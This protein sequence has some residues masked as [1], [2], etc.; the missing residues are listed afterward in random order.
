MNR[1]ND[2]TDYAPL[3][4]EALEELKRLGA[5]L[6]REQA[7]RTEPIAVVGLGC[8]FP[9][10]SDPDAYWELLRSGRDAITS[11]PADRWDA[12]ALLDPD[13]DAPG[14]IVTREGGFCDAVDQF[15]ARFFNISDRE[16]RE[17]DPQQRLLMEVSWEALENAGYAADRLY[18]S[19]AGVFVGIA[20]SDYAHLR[21]S[22]GGIRMI[23]AYSGTGNAHSVAAG[24]I[25]YSLGLKGP[26]LAVDTACSSSLV[27]VHLAVQSLRNNECD[28][29]LAGGV[30]LILAPGMSV[31]FSRVR[32]LSPNGRCRTFDAA[33]DG[34]V[35]GEGCGMIVLRRLSDA[36]ADGDRVLAVLRGSAV[37]HDGRSAGLTAPN[38]PSQEAVLNAAL[39]ESGLRPEE[40]DYI[41]AHGTGTPLGD[42][43]ELQAVARTYCPPDRARPLL[44]GSAKT[45]FGHL[46]AAAGIAGL[47]KLV[48]AIRHRQIPPNL[49]FREWNPHIA[50]DRKAVSV[51][52]RLQPWPEGKPSAVGA[53][54]SF[55]FSGT[56]AHIIVESAQVVSPPATG[57]K[58]LVLP[59]SAKSRSAL[60][61]LA[62]RYTA[63][64]R[65]AA[66]DEWPS[67]CHT[68]ALGRSHFQHRLAMVASSPAEAALL[69][70]AFV[71][72][73]A[74]AGVFTEASSS[75]AAASSSVEE[76]TAADYAAGRDVDWQ[77]LFGETRPL[78]AELPTYPFERE[79]Y[80]HDSAESDGEAPSV[81]PVAAS[82]TAQSGARSVAST[83]N[84][85]ARLG[86]R[87]SG[88]TPI[89]ESRPADGP[90]SFVAD[91]GVAGTPVV[92]GAAWLDLG[93]AA[94]AAIDPAGRYELANITFERLLPQAA[95]VGRTLEL[96]VL[97]GIDGSEFQI[98]SYHA[99]SPAGTLHARGRLRAAAEAEV[100]LRSGG[101]GERPESIAA[102]LG[103]SLDAAALYDRLE[104]LGLHYGP[105][106]RA[107]VGQVRHA[108]GEAL[109]E[110]CVGPTSAA[111][112]LPPWVIDACLQV[113]AAAV[114]NPAGSAAKA[115]SGL[116][117]NNGPLV[118]VGV[119]RAMI[120]APAGEKVFSHVRFR[121][122]AADAAPAAP[123]VDVRV[124]DA[125]GRVIA[126]FTGLRFAAASAARTA[127]RPKS[128]L[129]RL[130]KKA[131]PKAPG[132]TAVPA[133]G[134]G[135]HPVFAVEPDPAGEATLN[136]AALLAVPASQ[137]AARLSDYLHDRLLHALGRRQGTLDRNES[138]VNLGLDSL[139]V[140]KLNT[141]L[142]RALS[143]ELPMHLLLTGPSITQITELLLQ[144]LKEE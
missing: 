140:I 122:P 82:S 2:P 83:T 64:L 71:A 42:P 98:L 28:L 134:G 36:L 85:Q 16:A 92:P 39:A 10:A 87:L 107:V 37:N 118:P 135:L 29:A 78:R 65:G 119:D 38:G 101:D 12:D 73:G 126:E 47:I 96:V 112:P 84:R 60:A 139:M 123:V 52:D 19:T 109:G 132:A 46:E 128:V 13:P 62:A 90:W 143:V 79:R 97:P 76:R 94:A 105:K 26:C 33:A 48:L 99:G 74:P 115:N 35:R 51:A 89:F 69:L 18:G 95:A 49:H 120:F 141:Q 20:T 110:I 80:W 9:G 144:R 91:H 88:R 129:S 136:R 77:Q 104:K 56:N 121:A 130:N 127:E 66:A 131:S 116:S 63:R 117:A 17:I 32:M 113:C 138:L 114:P 137:R 22:V 68:A 21:Q 41:E 40:I 59:L 103:E 11:V 24:R 25:S 125:E 54:S 75:G 3:L 30:N 5:E 7:R 70:E 50:V 86:R 14:K 34:Y 72:G 31:T 142:E 6:D 45:N 27:A 81:A 4:R 43:I 8:R 57:A 93:A 108:A 58:R 133:S 53:V 106:F 55:G 23:D 61:A 124:L 44:V 67:I 1:P 102:R 100:A 15:D 111:D